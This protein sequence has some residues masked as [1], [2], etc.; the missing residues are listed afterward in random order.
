V[1]FNLTGFSLDIP[2]KNIILYLNI[3]KYASRKVSDLEKELEEQDW[4]NHQLF[5]HCIF[6]ALEFITAGVVMIYIVYK[7][8]MYLRRDCSNT[9][10]LKIES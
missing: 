7:L 9:L 6:S 4:R 2:H 10:C 8:Y 1:T 5:K 3:L